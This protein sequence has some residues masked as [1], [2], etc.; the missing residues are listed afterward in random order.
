MLPDSRGTASD[1]RDES[2][3]MP[4]IAPSVD[5]VPRKGSPSESLVGLLSS[6]HICRPWHVNVFFVP[7]EVLAVTSL[8]V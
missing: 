2:H 4:S 7:A 1:G 8:I 5:N 6:L 3:M